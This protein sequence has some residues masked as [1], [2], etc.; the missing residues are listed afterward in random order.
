MPIESNLILRT[1]LPKP[2]GTGLKVIAGY[3]SDIDALLTS[4]KGNSNIKIKVSYTTTGTP[5]PSGGGR[6][7]GGGSGGGSGGRSGGGKGKGGKEPRGPEYP[8][9]DLKFPLNRFPVAKALDLIDQVSEEANTIIRFNKKGKAIPS[10]TRKRGFQNLEGD[11]LHTATQTISPQGNVV[12]VKE[13][14]VDLNRIETQKKLRL[15]LIEQARQADNLQRSLREAAFFE[16]RGFTVDKASTRQAETVKGSGIYGRTVRATLVR[17]SPV[18]PGA[19]EVVKIDSRTKAIDESTRANKDYEKSQ[20]QI[21]TASDNAARG[22]TQSNQLIADG[23]TLV[24]TRTTTTS[25]GLQQSFTEFSRVSGS[26]LQGYQVEV[27]KVNTATGKMSVETLRGARAWRYLGDSVVRSVAKV[28]LWVT[29]TSLVFGTIR[30]IQATAA[31]IAELEN[32]TI[33][34]A[35]VGSRLGDSFQERLEG[36]KRLTNGIVKLSIA[37]GT[38]AAEGQQ[39]AAVFLRTGQ[40]EEQTLR[41]VSAAL[42]ASRIAEL[43]VVEAAN[44]LTAAQIQFKLGVEDLIPTL[45]TV[46]ELSNRYRVTSVDLLQAVSRSGSV[47][48]QQGGRFSE[49]AA[50]VAVTSQATARSGAEIG[51]AIKTIESRLGNAA[52][53]DTLLSKTG[54]AFRDSAGNARSYTDVLLDLQL[55]FAKLNGQQRDEVTIALAGVRQRNILIA[56]IENAV[57]ISIA[58]ARALRITGSAA[59]EA[60]DGSITLTSALLR[61]K[62]SLIGVAQ[63][64]SG[65]ILD[66]LKTV[67]FAIQSLVDGLS[68]F[69]SARAKIALFLGAMGLLN[70]ILTKFGVTATSVLVSII[71]SLINKFTALGQ[72]LISPITGFNLLGGGLIFA[73]RAALT[74]AAGFF[75]VQGPLIILTGAIYL[76]T[77]GMARYSEISAKA[78]FLTEQ[79][80]SQYDSAAAE[81]GKHRVAID[82]LSNALGKQIEVLRL[83]GNASDAASNAQRELA[84]RGIDKLTKELRKSNIKIPINFDATDTKQVANAQALIA[85][86]SQDKLSEQ[87]VS[88]EKQLANLREQRAAKIQTLQER[89]SV[90]VGRIGQES[91][92]IDIAATTFNFFAG[93][94]DELRNVNKELRL[95]GDLTV[96]AEDGIDEIAQK[97]R[98]VKKEAKEL[99]DQIETAGQLGTVKF[100]TFFNIAKAAGEELKRLKHIQK[101]VDDTNE[102]FGIDK[103]QAATEQFKT[104][105][106]EAIILGEKLA[107][108]NANANSDEIKKLQEQL[109]LTATE[110]RE[111]ASEAQKLKI[112]ARKTI[113]GK[114]FQFES[115]ADIALA[116]AGERIDRARKRNILDEQG[117]LLDPRTDTNADLRSKL[118]E[119]N[120]L[121]EQ[122]NQSLARVNKLAKG[123]N[124]PAY[125]ASERK[126]AQDTLNEAADKEL[127]IVTA[128]ADREADIVEQRQKSNEELQ[129]SLGLLSQEDK[130]RLI[131][132]AKYFQENPN[133]KVS[134]E[135]Q[136]LGSAESIKTLQEYFPQ[137]LQK[138]DEAQARGGSLLGPGGLLEGIQNQGLF[139]ANRAQTE[140]NNIKDGRTTR[141]LS[142]L[143]RNRALE[144]RTEAD[145]IGGVNA[146]ENKPV[147]DITTAN[148]G[149]ISL[150][151]NNIGIDLNPLIDKFEEV[152]VTRINE[153]RDALIARL[154][155]IEKDMAVPRKRPAT[156]PAVGGVGI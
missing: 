146:F 54:I 33:F 115:K 132:A 124:D 37:T 134:L 5:P 83:L 49:L 59:D 149:Q 93:T 114:N 67:V 152:T 65:P 75:V 72:V 8:V 64:S 144:N 145:R 139:E 2:R 80:A 117:N 56:Q 27:A 88:K 107:E 89:G 14:S 142:V 111:V 133:A 96:D 137:R 15:G 25:A 113:L 95:F 86:A 31:A 84:L 68:V 98:E 123:S 28:A 99:S 148:G 11:V 74:A 57:D 32:N 78:R 17:Q 94:A 44:L 16:K 63:G 35:R 119:R 12:N 125:L 42:I 23:F 120:R 46:N 150:N 116:T 103:Y 118:I 41:G 82:E 106:Q 92:G 61:L 90:L 126:F 127:E 24:G 29:A 87:R 69:D 20:K 109:K 71:S 58:E 26:A 156:A 91:G 81:A 155:L 105:S 104:L 73:G 100:N 101:S 153:L 60:A 34:L 50:V 30:G 19:E 55:A 22:I 130:A 18:F 21:Q 6:S 110:I 85:R 112:D 151:V 47:F 102:A 79:E 135:Q 1:T 70:I 136:F 97:M 43:G 108:A 122:A 128:V 7:G 45:D 77:V 36:A 131:L 39:A 40:D 10:T 143:A 53:A 62:A 141:G 52:T 13:K 140:L 4:I 3:L 147:T 51:N 66:F 76:L 38:D 9:R 129:K 138:L 48:E 121:V 154:E